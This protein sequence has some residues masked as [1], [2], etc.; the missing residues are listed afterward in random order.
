MPD[1]H[2]LLFIYKADSGLFNTASDIAHK[3]ISPQTYECDLCALT[4]GYFTMRKE[5]AGFLNELGLPCEFRHRDDVGTEPGIDPAVLPAI[6]RWRDDGWQLC[7]GPEQ[8]AACN[9]LEQLKTLVT[10]HCND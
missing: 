2:G 10:T 6:Y 3:I 1:E 9:D 4:H 5:W 7:T 8:I